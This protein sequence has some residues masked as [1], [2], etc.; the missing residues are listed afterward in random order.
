MGQTVLRARSGKL[1]NEN[2]GKV[3]CQKYNLD[4]YYINLGSSGDCLP[5]KEINFEPSKSKITD[6]SHVTEWLEE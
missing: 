6:D 2:L 4:V 5:D 3:Y 1:E